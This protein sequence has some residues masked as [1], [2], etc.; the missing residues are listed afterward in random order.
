[1]HSLPEFLVPFYIPPILPI[2]FYVTFKS[3]TQ[4]KTSREKYTTRPV[5]ENRGAQSCIHSHFHVNFISSLPFVI[6]PFSISSL[7]SFP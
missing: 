2:S 3:L 6:F 5:V 4:L 7:L 1:M